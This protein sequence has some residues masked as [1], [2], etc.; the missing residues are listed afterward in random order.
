MRRLL[1]LAW[2]VCLPLL[3]AS[4]VQVWQSNLSLWTDALH[5]AP[6][7]P[8]SLINYARAI[9]VEQARYA[10][11]LQFYQYADRLLDSRPNQAPRTVRMTARAD[12]AHC[13]TMTGQFADARRELLALY[14]GGYKDALLVRYYWAELQLATGNCTAPP[15]PPTPTAI[16]QHTSFTWTCPAVP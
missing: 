1:P 6:T 5:T 15:V 3:T 7:K 16:G 11:A 2:L 10:D 9:D 4:R 12:A 8:R 14:N 13:M